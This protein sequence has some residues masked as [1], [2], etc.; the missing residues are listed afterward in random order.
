MS[1]QLSAAILR[2]IAQILD[3]GKQ[4]DLKRA[5][6]AIIEGK[7]LGESSLDDKIVAEFE[8]VGFTEA[9]FRET[10]RFDYQLLKRH[11]NGG[12]WVPVEQ[13]QENHTMPFVAETAYI[14]PWALVSCCARVLDGAQVL[15]CS[16]VASNDCIGE[17]EVV[18]DW[19]Y[20]NEAVDERSIVSE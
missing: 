4:D 8:G 7:P 18:D 1:K 12:G 11:R 20:N 14:G 17:G 19:G 16:H 15:G 9:N 13:D 2:G 6:K 3:L 5:I 10:I